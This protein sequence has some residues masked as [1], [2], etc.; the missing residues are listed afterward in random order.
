MQA[1]TFE[2]YGQ[3]DVVRTAALPTPSPAD[4]EVLVRVRATTV[5][6]VDSVFRSG[7]TLAARLYT[8][9]LRPRLRVLGTE[10]AGEVEAVGARV[11]RFRVGDRVFGAPTDGVGAHA[12]FVCVPQAGVLGIMPAGLDFEQAAAVCNGALTA[13]PF[14]RDVGQLQAGQ[15]ILINGA[16][17]SIGSAAVQLAKQLGARVTA[18]AGPGRGELLRSLGADEVI[19]Y[20]THDFCTARN[21][22]DVIFDTVG[23]RSFG[24][25]RRAL[26]PAGR[27]LNPVLGL[28]LM[29][30]MLI[31]KLLGSRR[32]LFAATGLRPESTRA[33][34]L[35][36]IAGLLAR[37]S[38]RIPID[39]CFEFAQAAQA[40]RYVEAGHKAGNVVLLP[41]EPSSA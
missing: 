16:A 23:K 11:T 29:A 6:P 9:L 4:D 33:A 24:A 28:G 8:G 31:T 39:R 26:R 19:D 32:A 10:F 13:L 2:H 21:R 25:C 3:A 34:D 35:Q 5:T 18:V 41:P 38:L 12:Q 7:R 36:Q 15:H 30:S 37:G 17:G 1:I 14:L 40:Y 27:Y 20:R 22:Y